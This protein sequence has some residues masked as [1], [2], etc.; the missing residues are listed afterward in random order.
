MIF[1]GVSDTAVGRGRPDSGEMGQAD[2]SS[3]CDVPFFLPGIP[4]FR[5]Q[6]VGG[7]MD[8]LGRKYLE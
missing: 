3:N 1:Q 4:P 6:M 5:H 7:K 2:L 8:G